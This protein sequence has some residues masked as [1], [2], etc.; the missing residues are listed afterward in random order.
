MESPTTSFTR[1]ERL[2]SVI[3]AFERAWAGGIDPPDVSDFVPRNHEDS[4]E[5]LVELIR[6]D[7]DL[8]SEHGCRRP[9]SQYLV[10]FPEAFQDSETVSQ[11]AFEDYRVRLASGEQVTREEYAEQYG[12]STAAW[13]VVDSLTASRSLWNSVEQEASERS[14]DFPDVPSEYLGF[15]L[16]TEL[17]RGSFSRVYLARQ[18]DLASRFVVLKVSRSRFSDAD[19][20]AQLQHGHIVPIYSVHRSGKMTVVCMPYFGAATLADLWKSLHGMKSCPASGQIIVDTLSVA[21][22]RTLRFTDPG[23][24]S[25]SAAT[26]EIEFKADPDGCVAPS[27]D[28]TIATEPPLAVSAFLTRLSATPFVHAVLRMLA[29]LAD[30]LQHAHERGLLHRDLKPANILLADDGRPMLLDFNLAVSRGSGEPEQNAGGTLPYMSPEQLETLL[31]NPA[32]VDERSDLYSLGVILFELLTGLHPFPM[33]RGSVEEMARKMLADR[34]VQQPPIR[35]RN[36]LVTPAVEAIFRKCIAPDPEKRY[37]SAEQLKEDLE[38][39]LADLPLRFATE[40]SLRERSH[41]WLRRHTRFTAVSTVGLLAGGLF[42]GAGAYR[43]NERLTTL[44]QQVEEAM[45]SGQEALE[46]DDPEL[47]QGRFLRAWMLVQLEP[48]FAEDR[49]SVAGW[50]DHA[51]R[52]TLERQM[53][54]HVAPRTFELRRDEAFLLGMQLPE[55]AQPQIKYAEDAVRDSLAF[56]IAGDPGWTEE[57]RRL[58]LL[59]ADLDAA[60]RDRTADDTDAG[61]LQ[62]SDLFGLLDDPEL[63]GTREWHEARSIRLRNSGQ[64]DQAELEESRANSSPPDEVTSLLLEITGAARQQNFEP[65]VAAADR[66]TERHP[67]LFLARFLKAICLWKLKRNGEAQVC[68]E[69]CMA[70]RPD[71]LWTE[72]FLARMRYESG[73]RD[74][75]FRSFQE[76]LEFKPSPALQD[77]LKSALEHWDFGP[78]VSHEGAP[79]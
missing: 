63:S 18:S 47:A 79:Q 49:S 59:A 4:L 35:K 58:V 64:A 55:L 33:Y 32:C 37:Q 17:G 8:R 2:E 15:T 1:A 22:L 36:A 26:T 60:N 38:R 54:W 10:D 41:K 20:L 46:A 77:S 30:A 70:Q 53:K 78:P 11:V 28:G 40:P 5:I 51:R 24:S 43:E 23:K 65:A 39:H 42:L 66:L 3:E 57:R 31:G 6:V 56:T 72:Y 73:Q 71:F 14:T 45:A 9:L 34:N 44:E 25:H 74:E 48:S 19:Q 68:L 21:C 76:L 29:D 67:Q 52:A 75:A 12:I 13:P 69:A 27:Q 7:I 62:D 16:L 61:A 50:L